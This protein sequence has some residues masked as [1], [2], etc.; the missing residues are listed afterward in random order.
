MEED[1]YFRRAEIHRL[2]DPAVEGD[3]VP[4]VNLEELARA[5]TKRCHRARSVLSTRVL[6]TVTEPD[7]P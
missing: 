1:R 7:Q 6:M 3:A 2:H 4:D 5:A